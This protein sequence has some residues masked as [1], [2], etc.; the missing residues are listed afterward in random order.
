L[1]S[2]R[3][4][5]AS[6][7]LLW[8]RRT[9]RVMTV[10]FTLS[11]WSANFRDGSLSE[12]SLCW[13]AR[14]S[15]ETLHCG[16]P[17]A[18]AC[19]DPFRVT[20]TRLSLVGAARMQPEH[21]ADAAHSFYA[22]LGRPAPGHPPPAGLLAAPDACPVAEARDLLAG[23]GAS[24]KGTGY[25]KQRPSSGRWERPACHAVQPGGEPVPAC[26]GR[27]TLAPGGQP[28]C[29]GRLRAADAPVLR[30]DLAWSTRLLDA[31]RRSTGWRVRADARR[32]A[33]APDQLAF[34]GALP[35]TRKPVLVYP[36]ERAV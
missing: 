21:C 13:V 4:V 12:E 32:G 31:C 14:F 23:A 2:Q 5:R 27:V 8:L 7:T 34:T 35:Y 18:I 36:Y 17:R 16:L 26:G 11:G 15:S 33:P 30:S 20:L 10:C 29:A 6:L 3:D 25:I 1:S 22:S 28:V 19:G 24:V 9:L